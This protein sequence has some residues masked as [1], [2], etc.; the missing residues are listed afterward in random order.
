[1][2][3]LRYPAQSGTNDTSS[4]QFYGRPLAEWLKVGGKHVGLGW[5]EYYQV[6]I[7]SGNV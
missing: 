1:M 4:V 7:E 2:A 6:N 3:T 5:R